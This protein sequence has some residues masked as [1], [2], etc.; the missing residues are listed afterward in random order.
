MS[1][2][3]ISTENLSLDTLELSLTKM[4]RGYTISEASE[5]DS[6]LGRANILD[7]YLVLIE[8]IKQLQNQ[9]E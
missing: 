3:T 6:R 7:D 9:P 1:Q 2:I 4:F 8:I 5:I